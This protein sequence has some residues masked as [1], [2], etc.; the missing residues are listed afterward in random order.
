MKLQRENRNERKKKKNTNSYK[1]IW[2]RA[3]K[4]RYTNLRVAITVGDKR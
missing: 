4:A 2:Y 1:I 3:N